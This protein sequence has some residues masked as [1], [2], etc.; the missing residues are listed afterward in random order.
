VVGWKQLLTLT[1][2]LQ[3][4]QAVLA[5]FLIVI[6]VAS[7]LAALLVLRGGSAAIVAVPLVLGMSLFGAV[8][9]SNATGAPLV[10]AG[11]AIPAPKELVLGIALVLASLVWLVGRARIN[12]LASL[13]AARSLTGTVRQ[14]RESLS[15]AARRNGLAVAIVAIAV[16]AGLGFAP[17]AATL[18]PRQALRNGINPDLV[19]QRQPSPLSDYRGWFDTS[20][21]NSALFTVSGETHGIDRIQLATLNDYDGETFDVSGTATGQTGSFAHLPRTSP[22]SPGDVPLTITIGPAYSGI[23]VPIPAGLTAAPTFRGKRAS[24]LSDDFYI[25]ATESTAIDVAPSAGGATGLR[26]GDSYRLYAGAAPDT[27]ATLAGSTPARSSINAADYPALVDWVKAQDVP[28]NA[29]G[30]QLL[31]SRLVARGY[32]S[33]AL[34]QSAQ[35]KAWTAALD[36]RSAYAFQASYAGHSVARIESLFTTLLSQQRTAGA[37]ATRAQLVSGVGDDEQFATAAALLARYFGFDSRVVLGVRLGEAVPGFGVA[38]CSS[39]CK[40]GNLSAWIQVR[41]PGGPWVTFDTTPQYGT[42]PTTISQGEQLPSNPTV[43]GQTKN[44][45]VQPPPASRDNSGVRSAHSN[46]GTAWLTNLFAVLRVGGISLLALFLL[47]LPALVIL[48]AKGFRRRGRRDSPV[49]EVSLVGAWYEL[50]DLYVDSGIMLPKAGTPTQLARA[51]GRPAALTLADS[52]SRGVFGEHPPGRVVSTAAW[53]IVDA[54]RT[55]LA[56]STTGWRRLLARLGL[57]SFVRALDPTSIVSSVFSK[58]R[59]KEEA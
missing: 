52:V 17:V 46:S 9:G 47:L 29:H 2:P 36:A 57:A 54:E 41:T 39:V 11:I 43:P 31:L 35:S 25:S 28:R 23:W 7:L 4:Y 5:P 18:Q 8:F 20:R 55:Q 42:A 1:L 21:F 56:L 12:R 32:L 15:Y 48:F 19:V 33:H 13:N 30:L 50:V 44:T 58:L 40:G 27:A 26:P 22:S 24:Q 53:D 6:F 3:E 34:E 38:P 49:P 37:H 10:V 14:G 51:A 45:V 59:R 16:V